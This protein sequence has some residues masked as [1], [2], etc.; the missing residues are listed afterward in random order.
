MRITN[1]NIPGVMAYDL[2]PNGVNTPYFWYGNDA[3]VGTRAPFSTAPIGSIYVRIAAGS[4]SMWAKA[5]DNDA[6]ADWKEMC[7][8][9]NGSLT[10]SG[11]LT[12]GDIV[13]PV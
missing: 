1:D 13:S 3:I 9:L 2:D 4:V 7:A 12:A 5:T 8:T 11:T 10:I 6:T